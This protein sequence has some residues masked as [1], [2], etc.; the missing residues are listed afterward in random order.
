[1]KITKDA[2]VPALLASLV[3]FVTLL[4]ILW[5]IVK[6]IVAASIGEALADDI[7]AT[8]QREVAPIRGGFDVLLT[9]QIIQTQKAIALLERKG[10]TNLTAEETTQLVDLRAQLEAQQMALRELRK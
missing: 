3:S 2:G 6:P 5:F 4:G 1:M 7:K 10:L 8:V 9:Q